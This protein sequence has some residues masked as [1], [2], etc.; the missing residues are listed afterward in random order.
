MLWFVVAG[1]GGSCRGVLIK[2][3][4]ARARRVAGSVNDFTSNLILVVS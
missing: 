3:E 2:D 4:A 1:V